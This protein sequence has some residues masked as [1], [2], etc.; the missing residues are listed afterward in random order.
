MAGGAGPGS[1]GLAGPTHLACSSDY[2]WLVEAFTRLSEATGEARWTREAGAA[3]DALIDL[4]WDPSVGG[5][6]TTGND[7]EQLIARMKDIYDGAVPSANA[8]AA[9]ALA[10]LGELTGVAR[11]EELARQTVRALRPALAVSPASFAGTALA[12]DFWS[13][14]RRQVVVSSADP[15]LVRPVWARYLP[16]TVLA[17]AEPYPSPLWAGRDDAG[18]A[19]QVF[20]CEGYTCLLP[21]REAGQV[22]AL[23]G[24]KRPSTYRAG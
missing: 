6:F 20:V 23:L 17:W 21:V 13:A 5:F 9:V 24:P 2:A 12:A 3:A 19:G 14:P 18:A 1:P 7:A 10:R 22:D 11:Y 4:F 8:T 16:D 15:A